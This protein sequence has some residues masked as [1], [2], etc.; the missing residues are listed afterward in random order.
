MRPICLMM[1]LTTLAC[2][3]WEDPPHTV[4]FEEETD[5]R[6]LL[7]PLTDVPF[8]SFSSKTE[9]W[10][11][12]LGEFAAAALASR[13]GVRMVERVTNYVVPFEH[14]EEPDSPRWAMESVGMAERL[15]T[16]HQVVVA[17]VGTGVNH[18]H[19]SI[20]P[21]LWV[22]DGEIPDN[23]LDDDANGLIDDVFGWD[24]FDDDA[25]PSPAG[26]AID[27]GT[28]SASIVAGAPTRGAPVEGLASNALVMPLR[29]GQQGATSDHLAD[30]IDYAWTNGAKVILLGLAGGHSTLVEEALERAVMAGVTIVAP[31]SDDPLPHP[32]VLTA[33]GHD[34]TGER[35]DDFP[36]DVVA[37]GRAVIGA[38]GSEGFAAL[39]GNGVAAA[40]LAGVL[41]VLAA[42][43]SGNA[44][45]FSQLPGTTDGSPRL[46]APALADP[47]GNTG[48][49]IIRRSRLS[50]HLHTPRERPPARGFTIEA[51]Q[52]EPLEISAPDWLVLRGCPAAPCRVEVSVSASGLGE[53]F[54]QGVIEVR[55]LDGGIHRIFVDVTV[56]I[57]DPT[58]HIE[59]RG[60]A[61]D[62]GGAVWRV[63]IGQSIEL[64][65]RAFGRPSTVRWEIDGDEVPGTTLRG[66]FLREGRY[67]VTATRPGG[68]RAEVEIRAVHGDALGSSGLDLS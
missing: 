23:G 6:E 12:R 52:E 29:V 7:E 42:Q 31:A 3:G 32:G 66:A 48:T 13:P 11:A 9:R 55:R 59:V 4:V 44:D 60:G 63:P 37:P 36:A 33:A 27:S 46:F 28:H 17:V 35:I 49:L 24:F 43:G 56:G 16:G 40:H 10:T 14:A 1:L 34:R 39:S 15:R 51:R 19:P 30:A 41:A 5:V 67:R 57:M 68:G 2:D 47:P 61:E 20:A 58:L 53:G 64:S 45:L 50:F 38:V 21:R 65:G 26:E 8:V 25:D 54:H 22:N 18:R 62:S